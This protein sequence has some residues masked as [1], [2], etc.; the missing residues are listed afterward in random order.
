M[1]ATLHEA[2]VHLWQY[3]PEFF[4]QW[5]VF[6][7][8]VVQKM[9]THILCSITH[10][11]KSCRFWDNVEKYDIESDKPRMTIWRMRIACWI[12]KATD[13]HSEYVILTAVPP[14]QWV[15]EY[16][17]MLRYTYIAL[18]IVKQIWKRIKK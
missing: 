15:H 16:A 7:T 18:I 13:T 3:C 9:K 11:R 17:S 2:Y 12:P 6:Q 14:E 5:Q 8:K 10:F 1:A 4:S